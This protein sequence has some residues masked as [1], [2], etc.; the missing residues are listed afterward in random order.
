M[1]M[2][3]R[4]LILIIIFVLTVPTLLAESIFCDQCGNRIK[5]GKSCLVSGG[6]I[7]CDE[8]CYEN[9]LP[10]CVVCRKTV[11]SGFVQDGKNYC[12]EE[13]LSTTWNSCS[14]CGKRSASGINF[15]HSS[16]IF[17]CRDCAKKPV[18]TGCGLPN[19]GSALK[20][21][22]LMCDKCLSTAVNSHR[23]AMDIIRNVRRVMM[24][25]FGLFTGNEIKYRLVGLNELKKHSGL[26]ELEL[27]LFLH[28]QWKNTE[29]VIKK[30][31][32]VKVGEETSVAM[33]DS[34]TILILTSL[35]E[36]KFTEVA[37]HELAHDWMEK[38][39]PAIKDRVLIEGWAEYVS[40]LVN[41]YFGKEYLNEQKK[42]ND[43]PVYGKG[44]RLLSGIAGN[45]GLVKVIDFLKE[46]NDE[47]R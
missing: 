6:K 41:S 27:G 20:D 7:F 12:G 14:L 42:F 38:N 17:Y 47:Y 10:K 30:R 34:F 1:Y 29:T 23:H 24:E 35:P 21:G 8:E 36:D 28:E 45:E 40:S 16:G 15:G 18:C 33:S 5:E 26:S 4:A 2:K 25:Q 22:R 11:R 19:N 31:L 9:S 43:D 3:L 44:Y 32:G 37:A 46:K 13:C 39:F